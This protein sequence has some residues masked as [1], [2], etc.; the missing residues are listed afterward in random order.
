MKGMPARR[1]SPPPQPPP[2]VLKLPLADAEA[3]LTDLIEAGRELVDSDA[4]RLDS[5]LEG[6]PYGRLMTAPPGAEEV[7]ALE[8]KT[9][10]W[11]DYN[12]TWLDRNLGGEA[13]GEYERASTH[14]HVGGSKNPRTDLSFLASE[15]EQ[16]VS[17]L[18]SICERLP[19][20]A[21]QEEVTATSTPSS[22]S[23][24]SKATTFATNRKAVM[25]IYGH[26]KQANDALFD[27]LRSIGLQPQEWSHIMAASGSASPY[28]GQALERA[29]E[30]AQAVVAF[31]TPDE[32][33]LAVGASPDNPN[34]WRLQARPNV[35]I[36]AGMALS[37][38]PTRTVLVVL[39]PQDLPSDLAGRH[40]VRLTDAVEPLNDLANRLQQAGC[41]T[42]TRGTSW[43]NSARFPDRRHITP[44]PPAP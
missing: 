20:W 37:I 6:M 23:S 36:E 35:L 1:Q 17:K 39:G 24:G 12:R 29:F 5:Q 16:E 26:D 30:N 44:A 18:E 43:L 3:K 41:D 9:G 10:R 13:A 4:A 22:S 11:R 42:D 40:Y 25:V 15:I 19:M 32:R 7:R 2:S 33:V 31:F 28:I 38:H 8:R 14:W 27:W 34:A 21:P